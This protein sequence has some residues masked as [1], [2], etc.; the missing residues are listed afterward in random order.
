MNGAHS[1]ELPDGGEGARRAQEEEVAFGELET[2]HR[3]DAARSEEDFSRVE[4][5]FNAGSP[6]PCEMQQENSVRARQLP[7]D[8]GD[9]DQ[10]RI[11]CSVSAPCGR[12]PRSNHA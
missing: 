4:G 12:S 10:V 1:E 2:E 11:G 9:P 7:D 5:E 3:M 8:S 6:Y